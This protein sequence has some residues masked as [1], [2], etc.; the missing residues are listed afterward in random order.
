MAH[1]FN[2]PLV[3]SKCH[4]VTTK[5]ALF[6]RQ[7]RIILNVNKSHF[8]K[9]HLW[10]K[11]CWQREKCLTSFREEKWTSVCVCEQIVFWSGWSCLWGYLCR[12]RSSSVV[13]T[14]CRSSGVAP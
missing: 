6:A 10:S 4:T 8:F 3:P 14:M 2:Y 9:Y 1:G 11:V 12:K 7:F 13:V 5:I